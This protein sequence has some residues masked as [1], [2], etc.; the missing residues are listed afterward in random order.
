MPTY[1]APDRRK[2]YTF[3]HRLEMCEAFVEGT[4]IEDTI[5]SLTQSVRMLGGIGWEHERDLVLLIAEK[6][7]KDHVE[8]LISDCYDFEEY[9]RFPIDVFKHFSGGAFKM[10]EEQFNKLRDC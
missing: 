3:D 8:W 2:P 1:I 7:C 6:V 5:R 4:E 9:D 10:D